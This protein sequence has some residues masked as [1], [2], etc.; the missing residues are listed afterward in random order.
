MSKKSKATTVA[1]KAS[2]AAKVAAQVAP[3]ATPALTSGRTITQIAAD[4]GLS[5]KNARRILR[6]VKSSLADSVDYQ[7]SKG[8]RHVLNAKQ[9]Q[10]FRAIVASRKA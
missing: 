10:A 2:R 9:E 6:R 5:P 3:V 7:H 4:L 8:D 1:R